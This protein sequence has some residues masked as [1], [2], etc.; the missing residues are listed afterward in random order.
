MELAAMHKSSQT[1]SSSQ[2]GQISRRQFLNTA[3]AMGAG[4]LLAPASG[5]VLGANDTVRLAIVGLR[6]KGTQHIKLFRQVKGVR[7]VAICD[8]DQKILRDRAKKHFDNEVDTYTDLRAILDRQDIDAVCI[9]TP[10][11]WHALSAI[12]ACQA[13]KDVYLE[14]PISHNI[15]EG[16]KVVDAARRYNRVVQTGTQS[17][18]CVG[19][20]QF[21]A[22]LHAG[23][24]GKI[25]VARGLCYKRRPSIGH[26][27][28]PQPIPDHIDYNLWSGPR[29]P[30]PLMRE[31][32]HY[33]WHWQWL[34]G[35]GD[36]ANQGVHQLDLARWALG[37]PKLAPSVVSLGG[38]FGYDDNGQTPNTHSIIYDY[39]TA[40]LV[41]EVRGLPARKK[42][43]ALPH[44]RQ[45][46]IAM[47]IETEAGYFAGTNG[48]SFFDWDGNQ[49]KR[50]SPE[51][52]EQ[53]QANFIEA[54]R[55]NRPSHLNAEVE[56]GHISSALAHMGNISHQ[57]GDAIDQGELESKTQTESLK[58]NVFERLMQHASVHEDNFNDRPM[59]L[60]PS[61][62]ME[63]NHERF[64]GQWA[65]EANRLVRD[66]YRPP[67]VVPERV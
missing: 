58:A 35:N 44:Y 13:G 29:V 15:W 49:V 34:T 11:H 5:K 56:E 30:E 23:R 57:V 25:K 19:T 10:N 40:P 65:Y 1:T 27:K 28:S 32:L 43:D 26:V 7:I 51:G 48:G 61:L 64:Q 52:P 31:R 67:F 21:I 14:K 63:P 38:R 12:W 24:Y 45:A 53:H 8:V 33:D 62:N 54:V 37:E 20:Q 59:I 18:S 55:R 22:D 42:G 2:R 41:F 6:G 50:Y 9:A 47:V 66:A 17:R 3:A 60:G 4:V 36:I 39:P 46:R 16:R